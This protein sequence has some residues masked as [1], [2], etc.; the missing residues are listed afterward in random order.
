MKETKKGFTQT[1]L[2]NLGSFIEFFSSKRFIFSLVKDL[3]QEVDF[4][5]RRILSSSVD[6]M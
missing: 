3:V 2:R 1:E 6:K 4:F 5:K